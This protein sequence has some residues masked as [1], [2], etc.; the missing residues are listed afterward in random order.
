MT[1]PL[2]LP[3]P[4]SPAT[5]TPVSGDVEGVVGDVNLEEMRA[6]LTALLFVAAVAQG[7]E[8]D[9]PVGGR[10]LAPGELAHVRAEVRNIRERATF[11]TTAS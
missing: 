4:H 2:L 10:Q 11:R 3:A 9:E 5:N 7:Q 8:W 6:V 1:T